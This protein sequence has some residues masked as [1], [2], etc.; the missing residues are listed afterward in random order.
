MSDSKNEKYIETFQD[1][2]FKEIQRN[3]TIADK[4]RKEKSEEEIKERFFHNKEKKRKG[5]Y[6]DYLKDEVKHWKQKIY[7]TK[8]NDE[9][10]KPT[11]T[12][13]LHNMDVYYFIERI[14]GSKVAKR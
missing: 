6:Q 3:I 11:F 10:F 1:M 9:Q 4:R 14:D 8:S 5:T 7:G 13:T 2:F 12:G